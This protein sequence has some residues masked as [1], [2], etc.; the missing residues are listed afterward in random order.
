MAR[1]SPVKEPAWKSASPDP[2]GELL[3]STA[4][5]RLQVVML[6]VRPQSEYN[7]FHIQ[8]A[9]NVAIPELVPMAS[10]LNR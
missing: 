1:I 6:D 8:G 10:Q 3:T 7:L 5:D 9:Q 2:P 4:D